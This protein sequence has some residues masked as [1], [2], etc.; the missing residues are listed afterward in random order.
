ME[1]ASNI[2]LLVSERAQCRVRLGIGFFMALYFSATGYTNH[3]LYIF[4]VGYCF[5]FLLITKV[6]S[7]FSGTRATAS[8][9]LDNFFTIAGLHVTGEEGTFL[10]V[11]LIQ[12]SLGNGLRYGRRYLWISVVFACVGLAALYSFPTPWEGNVHLAIAYILGTPFIAFYIDHLVSQLRR[13]KLS[14]ERRARDIA[15]LFRFLSHDIRTPLH[16]IMSTAAAAR[17]SASD[18]G[19]EA[20]LARIESSV[21]SLARLTT[22]VLSSTWV[23]GSQPLQNASSLLITEWLVEVTRRF[24]DEIEHKGSEIAYSFDYS[25]PPR[26][27]IDAIAAERLILNALSNAARHTG[28]SPIEIS[29]RSTSR[30]NGTDRI[31]IRIVNTKDNRPDTSAAQDAEI[32]ADSYYGSGLGLLSAQETARQ[33]GGSFSL[34][35]DG[36]DRFSALIQLPIQAVDDQ[37]FWIY[38]PII[39]VTR[40]EA[41][42]RYV[43]AAIGEFCDLFTIESLSTFLDVLK[44]PRA[45]PI[46]GLLIDADAFNEVDRSHDT[47]GHM[48]SIRPFTL[49]QS[50]DS[51]PGSVGPNESFASFCLSTPPVELQ[52]ALIGQFSVRHVGF[53]RMGRGLRPVRQSPLRARVLVAEDNDVI[54][55]LFVNQLERIVSEVVHCASA[56]DA[57]AAMRASEFDCV[58]LDWNLRGG[59]A[60]PVL[61]ACS[62]AQH[63]KTQKLFIVSGEERNIIQSRI[64]SDLHA[65]IL[66]RSVSISEQVSQIGGVLSA[67]DENE[68]GATDSQQVKYFDTALYEEMLDGG[69]NAGRISNLV[70]RL[71]FELQE[72]IDTTVRL[73]L[74]NDLERASVQIHNLKGMAFTGGAIAL[75]RQLESPLFSSLN[76]ESMPSESE[77]YKKECEDLVNIW[78]ITRRYVRWY[79]A[80]ISS[81]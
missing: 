33:A 55:K 47:Q 36:D 22:N 16:A 60:E 25:I 80:S 71:E 32:G 37:H 3:P 59:T 79:L 28:G 76:P 7:T 67:A 31:S 53:L 69:L 51:S 46:G 66:D 20:K 49:I 44:D 54:A 34:I 18:S 9:A 77:S 52:S 72:M 74:E 4:F 6:A 19:T 56:S 30:T 73:M 57:I 8:I 2:E 13:S 39:L 50:D 14:A 15:E 68:R 64:P 23:K 1:Q 35:G 40:S 75:G 70:S 24:F 48:R 43:N 61:H 21:R 29:L 78:E 45:R 26:I 12:I 58:I 17:E 81:R 38:M 63:G 10:F 11:L 62:T 27:R 5:T 42:A 41:V 65:V